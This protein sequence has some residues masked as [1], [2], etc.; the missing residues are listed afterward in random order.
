M[1]TGV[2]EFYEQ[3]AKTITHE[4]QE[5]MKMKNKHENKNSLDFKALTHDL[6]L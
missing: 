4:C 1:R 5:L 2:N 6:K 3:Y